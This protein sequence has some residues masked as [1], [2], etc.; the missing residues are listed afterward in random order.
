MVSLK[1]ILKEL[2]VVTDNPSGTVK[3]GANTAS[4]LRQALGP[5]LVKVVIS[6]DL[7]ASVGSANWNDRSYMGDRDSELNV[8]FMKKQE[9]SVIIYNNTIKIIKLTY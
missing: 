6:D 3:V 9:S 2:N 4:S 5:V 1:K 8:F 7:Y